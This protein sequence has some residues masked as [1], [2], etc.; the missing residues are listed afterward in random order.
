MESEVKI[1]EGLKFSLCNQC[2]KKTADRC[3]MQRKD[4]EAIVVDCGRFEPDL[5][6]TTFLNSVSDVLERRLK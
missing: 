4:P 2:C 5:A 3:S 6:K 1:N